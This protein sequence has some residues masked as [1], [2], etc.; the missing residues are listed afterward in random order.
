MDS[1]DVVLIIAT[2]RSKGGFEVHWTVWV[3]EAACPR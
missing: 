1:A 2:E 3:V